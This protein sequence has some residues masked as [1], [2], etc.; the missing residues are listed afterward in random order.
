ML[1]QRKLIQWWQAYGF[2]VAA[3]I[4]STDY[5]NHNRFQKPVIQGLRLPELLQII[6]TELNLAKY[7]MGIKPDYYSTFPRPRPINCGRKPRNQ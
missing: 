3:Q 2:R 1:E 6:G 4:P 5:P 7:I